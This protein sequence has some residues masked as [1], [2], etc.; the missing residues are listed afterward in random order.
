MALYQAYSRQE[1]TK[2]KILE[3]R[4]DRGR[5]WLIQNVRIFVGN[6]KVIE[7]GAVLIK[8]GKIAEIYEGAS[9]SETSLNAKAIDAAGK[10]VL[11]GLIDMHVHLGASGGFYDDASK[12]FDPRDLEREL[13]SYLYCGVTAV[14]SAGDSLDQMVKL[15]QKFN[16]G[17]KLGAE[18]FFCGPLF[19]AEGGHGTEYARYMPENMRAGFLAQ[20]VRIP[21]NPEEAKSM[22]DEVT[23]KGVDCIKGVLEAGA[24][25]YT[26]NR[27][28]V[29]LLRMVADEAHAKK[30][31]VAVHTGNAHDVDDAISVGANSIEHG[32]FADEISDN[33]IAEMKR[34]GV[35]LDPTLSVAEGLTSFAR[36][37]TRLLKRSLVQQVTT[38]E[39]LAGTERAA[40][41]DQYKGLREGLSHYP[42]SLE[43]GDK[44]LLKA[45]HAGVT[46]IT[47]S[48]AGN[49]FVLHGSTIQHEV[50]LGSLLEFQ[51]RSPCKPRRQTLRRFCAWKIASVPSKKERKLHC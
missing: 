43:A 13:A 21:K 15:R 49:F 34:R 1:I 51:L 16:T 12:G 33:A 6:G 38:K 7:N 3:R 26:F 28:D 2:A 37:D 4:I 20:F 31:P 44:N 41:S 47:G 19:T 10:T 27:M 48:D 46:L 23:S 17:E 36:G 9:P 30:L 42:I 35:A 40:T 24:P 50:E 8:Q 32:S 22:V 25:G 14:R 11:P 5:T 39:L 18:L 29:N 45:W